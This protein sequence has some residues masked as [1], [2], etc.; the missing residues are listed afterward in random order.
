MSLFKNAKAGQFYAI[1]VGPGSAD[2]LTY[3]AAKIIETADVVIA[4]RSRIAAESLALKTVK[5]L[6]HDD[7]EVIDHVYAMKRD[8]EKCHNNWAEI[9]EIVENR[10]KQGKSVVQITIGDPLV[11]ST[12]YY[13]IT[14]LRKLISNDKISVIPG[15][16]AFQA[17]AAKFG[18]ALTIQEDRMTLMPATCLEQVEKAIQ[19]CETLVLYKAGKKIAEL[20]ELFEKYE[21]INSAKA[22]FY[23]EQDEREFITT[24]LREVAG[25]EPGYMATVIVHINR[26]AWK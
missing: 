20:A 9:A 12:S 23:A 17:I 7:Q 15:I 19:N 2:L 25:K 16:S 1:G 18:D 4:P 3:R 6:I 21:I 22:I 5:E 11:Y 10:V 26:R 13:L 24:D 8:S 14:E